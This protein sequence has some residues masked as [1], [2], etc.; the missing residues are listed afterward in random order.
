MINLL[1]VPIKETFRPGI[2]ALVSQ[3]DKTIQIVHSRSI[4]KLLARIADDLVSNKHS[5]RL[6]QEKYNLGQLGIVLLENVDFDDRVISSNVGIRDLI[7]RHKSNLHAEALRTQGYTIANAYNPVS[8]DIKCVILSRR[9]A[10]GP[11]V[12]I[13]IT[14]GTKYYVQKL[15]DTVTEAE[16]YIKNTDM[17]MM[18]S[19]TNGSLKP[20]KLEVAPVNEVQPQDL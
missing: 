3:E 13:K 10:T 6:M 1:D 4:V 11:Q 2:I 16:E 7:L 18:L 9:R 19:D 17:I 12:R 14:R 15:F 5:N 8:F 20:F